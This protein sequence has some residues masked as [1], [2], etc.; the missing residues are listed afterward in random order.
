MV[1]HVK[2]ETKT[3]RD[4]YMRPS[5]IP[6]NKAPYVLSR[7][8]KVEEILILASDASRLGERHG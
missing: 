3:I 8:G 6:N 5:A 7:L 2:T 4:T 1:L